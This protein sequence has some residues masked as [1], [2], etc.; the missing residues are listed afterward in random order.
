[1]LQDRHNALDLD[2]EIRKLGR[3]RPGMLLGQMNEGIISVNTGIDII[4]P[5]PSVQELVDSLL[6]VG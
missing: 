2:D 6:D 4:Q 5:I 1:M 3:L